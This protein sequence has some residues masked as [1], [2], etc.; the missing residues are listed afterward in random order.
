MDNEKEDL[1]S[2][3]R[4]VKIVFLKHPHANHG[5]LEDMSIRTFL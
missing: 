5:P 3:V 2:G 4:F 1:F